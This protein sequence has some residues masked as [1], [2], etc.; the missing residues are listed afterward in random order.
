MG[1]EKESNLP[2][3]GKSSRR[4]AAGTVLQGRESRGGALPVASQVL[5]PDEAVHPWLGTVE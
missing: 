3:S 5:P 2:P 1:D 4:A